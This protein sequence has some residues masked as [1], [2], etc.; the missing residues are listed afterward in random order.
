M[1]TLS[2]PRS[3]LM[4]YKHLIIF[5][6]ALLLW[7][8]SCP[9]MA[10]S[11]QF[12]S[13]LSDFRLLYKMYH[14]GPVLPQKDVDRIA[15]RIWDGSGHNWEF[16]STTACQGIC[17]SHYTL[18]GNKHLKYRGHI[19]MHLNTIFAEGVR[20][21]VV[22]KSHN[23]LVWLLRLCKKDPSYAD[24]LS[25]SRLV[26]LTQHFGSLRIA[27]FQYVTGPGYKKH[28]KKHKGDF[29]R[30]LRYWMTVQQLKAAY[31]DVPHE[32]K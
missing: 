8:L 27:V 24:F 26:F 2:C 19:G 9:V 4:A 1:L 29:K 15:L 12:D 11:P 7:L 30:A 21:H 16:A 6:A 25:A 14:M 32:G 5:K 23:D 3:N 22:K 18:S 10:Q 13:F 17:E 28:D 31:F 20:I